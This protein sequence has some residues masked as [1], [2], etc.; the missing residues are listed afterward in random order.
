LLAIMFAPPPSDPRWSV[1]I[2]RDDEAATAG[3]YG[4]GARLAGATIEAIGEVH[5]V[6][7]AGRGRHEILEL[8]RRQPRAPADGR[9]AAPDALAAGVRNTGPR[10]YEVRRAALDQFLAGGMTPPWPRVVPQARDGEPVGLRLFGI[11][12]DGPF[13]AIGLRDGDL[14]R[15]VNGK[16]IATPDAALAAYA[17]LRTAGHVWL[18]I[19]RDGQRIRLDY[20][21]R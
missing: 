14:L 5:V 16:S 4:L 1:A 12:R 13:A 7:D 6:L 19:E 18:V 11:G 20:V 17:T 2:I 8:L 15:E 9:P 3:P 21:I 10:S